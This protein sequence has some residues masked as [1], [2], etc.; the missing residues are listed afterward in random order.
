M[1]I[2]GYFLVWFVRVVGITG[3]TNEKFIRLNAV[4]L[5]AYC[6][7]RS[8][9]A[10]GD[11]KILLSAF[12]SPALCTSEQLVSIFGIFLVILRL[13][14]PYFPVNGFPMLLADDFMAF[15]AVG[16]SDM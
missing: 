6:L 13:Y 2:K 1:V 16:G 5:C 15:V 4:G 7:N 10:L 8:V 11:K 9:V 12:F 3:G 14:I